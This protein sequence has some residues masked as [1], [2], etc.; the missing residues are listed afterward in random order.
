MKQTYYEIKEYFYENKNKNGKAKEK[1]RKLR[2]ASLP[3]ELRKPARLETSAAATAAAAAA[4]DAAAAAAKETRKS[5]TPSMQREN[6]NQSQ[7][8]GTDIFIP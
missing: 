1:I 8:L 4:G 6:K 5:E 7:A 2:R 3:R